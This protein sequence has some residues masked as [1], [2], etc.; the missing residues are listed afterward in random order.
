VF[1]VSKVLPENAKRRGT[2]AACERSLGRLRTDRLDCYLLHWESSHPLEATIA[3]FDE[4]VARGKILSFG[5]SN[6]D[7]VQ[8]AEAVAIAGEGKIACN[9]VLYHLEERTIE[10][11]LLPRCR[12]LGVAVVGYSPF[13]QGNLPSTSGDAGRTLA[14]VA[15]AHAATPAQVA[16]AFLVRDP[17]VFAIPKAAR[18]EH[19][20][21]NAAA[22]GIALSSADVERIEAAFP[23]GPRRAGIAML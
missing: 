3:A 21:E 7:E 1:L 15:A 5:V 4:L 16:L 18:P 13:A 8:L 19:V 2:I 11:A 12:E 23:L 14:E 6:F 10:H 9:Q 22:T 17:S 20:R